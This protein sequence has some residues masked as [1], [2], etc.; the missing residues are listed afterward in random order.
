MKL[1]LTLVPFLFSSLALADEGHGTVSL[2]IESEKTINAGKSE[3]SF[4][5][6]DSKRNKNVTD[7]DLEVVHEKKIHMLVFDKSLTQFFH[8]HPEFKTSNWK[9]NADIPTNGKY[10]IYIEGKQ[11]TSGEFTAHDVIQVQKGK[12]ELPAPNNVTPQKSGASGESIVTLS[13]DTFSTAQD[14]HIRLTFS[15]TDGQRPKITNYLGAKAHVVVTPLDG[16]ELLHVHPMEEGSDIALG[17]HTRFKKAGD[18]RM[19][20]EFIDQGVKRT[21]PL[22]IRATGGSAGGHDH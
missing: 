16:S 7:S 15:R 21:V 13:G 8:I 1:A 3:V 14:S 4:N 18:Y 19:W 6:F 9:V 12:P 17:L 2:K 20:I 11:K 10:H 5:L 22:W